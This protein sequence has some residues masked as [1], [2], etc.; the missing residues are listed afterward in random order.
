MVSVGSAITA[1]AEMLV[2]F[3]AHVPTIL[4]SLAFIKVS[5]IVTF[6]FAP[7]NPIET[8]ATE[9]ATVPDV[10]DPRISK[11]P[12]TRLE[13]HAEL[14]TVPNP[15]EIVGVYETQPVTGTPTGAVCGPI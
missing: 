1:L 14:V 15:A 10:R 6:A 11:F 3:P 13:N 7:L 4:L 12:P 8:V 5:S 2:P 9:L